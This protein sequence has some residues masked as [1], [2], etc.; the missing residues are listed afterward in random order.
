ML[1]KNDA[2][3]YRVLFQ[4]RMRETQFEVNSISYQQVALLKDASHCMQLSMVT[5]GIIT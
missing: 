3:K 1:E 2:I 5:V 4:T